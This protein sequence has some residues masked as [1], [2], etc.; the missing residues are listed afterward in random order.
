[1][2]DTRMFYDL[3]LQ[4]DTTPPVQNETK[5][6]QDFRK[7]WVHLVFW[8]RMY[9]LSVVD[10]L[11]DRAVV[12]ERVKKIPQ[13][14]IDIFKS[15]NPS[16][17]TDPLRQSM[18]DFVGDTTGLMDAVKEGDVEKADQM[19]AK[20]NLDI[21]QLASAFNNLSSAYANADV[22]KMLKEYLAL[23]KQEI[24]ARM[25]SDFEKDVRTV[26]ELEASALRTADYLA[27]GIGTKTQ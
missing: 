12:A 2:Y 3:F 22:Q 4:E 19:E 21:A 1:M 24:E 15:N 18:N 17:V 26:D 11:E 7:A 8:T 6:N 10:N 5:L 16:S 14:M 13:E 9:L 27:N 20:I 23:T 25:T